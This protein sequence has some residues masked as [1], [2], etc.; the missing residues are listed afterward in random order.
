MPG[1]F[2]GLK[3]RSNGNR[4]RSGAWYLRRILPYRN[5]GK[6]IE[7]IVV[8]F[9]DI[10]HQ[11]EAAAALEH[12]RLQADSANVAK[13]RFLAAAS[14]DLRQPL[15]T[16]VLLQELLAKVVVGEKAQKLVAGSIKPWAACPEC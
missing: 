11:K 8:T 14:H 6:R 5:E 2:C 15:Q 12:A 3:N 13:S 4:S 10:T 16:L 9:V 1:E 7:G